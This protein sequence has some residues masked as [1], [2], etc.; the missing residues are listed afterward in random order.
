MNSSEIYTGKIDLEDSISSHDTARSQI[1]L[2]TNA[3]FKEILTLA[4]KVAN[5]TTPVLIMGESGSGKELLARYIHEMSARNS[6]SFVGVNCAAI[7]KDLM[8]SE[9]FGFEAGAFTGAN[10][11]REGFFESANQGTLF[12]DEVAEMPMSLQVKLLRAIQEGEVRRLGALR[13]TEVDVRIISATNKSLEHEIDKKLF[14][15]DLYYRIGVF[16][17]EIPPLRDRKD[18]IPLLAKYFSEK[19]AKKQGR[20]TPVLSEDALRQLIAYS[21]PGNV[22]ELE[23]VIERALIFSEERIEPEHLQFM[24]GVDDTC[25]VKSLAEISQIALQNA[26]SA[27]ILQALSMTGGNRVKAAGLL[28]VSYK[29]LLNKIRLYNIN[30]REDDE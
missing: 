12:L 6:A 9:F 17:L 20:L 22:R 1:I 8:E 7:P 25:S 29:T 4:R 15:D 3:Y 16:V 2:T 18:D 19:F 5:L 14:R 27:A 13:S 10:Y 23:N 28:E 30:L 26:E 24:K 21:W 11:S